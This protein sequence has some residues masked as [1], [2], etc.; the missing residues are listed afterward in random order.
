MK[1]MLK[2]VFMTV[3]LGLLGIGS[4]MAQVS[5]DGMGKVLPAELFVCK[6]RNRQDEGRS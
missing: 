5:E 2:A 3:A 6:Y 4:P 1:K